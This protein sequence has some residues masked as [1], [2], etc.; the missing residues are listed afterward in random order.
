[1]TQRT[2]PATL[3]QYG[4]AFRATSLSATTDAKIRAAIDN[5]QRPR[6]HWFP[7]VWA[8]PFAAACAALTLWIYVSAD[9]HACEVTEQSDHTRYAGQCDVELRTMAV[10]LSPGAVVEEHDSRVRLSHGAAHFSVHK[11]EPGHPPVTVTL[12]DA[13]IEV[14]GTE[15]TVEISHNVSRVH[16]Q[17]GRVRFLRQGRGLDTGAVDMVPGQ[18]LTFESRTGK[19]EVVTLDANAASDPNRLHDALPAEPASAPVNATSSP[20]SAPSPEPETTS[21]SPNNSNDTKRTTQGAARSPAAPTAPTSTAATNTAT[22][23]TVQS[24]VLDEALRLRAAGRYDEALAALDDVNPQG[25][26]AREV[27]DYERAALTE[28]TSPARACVRY[29]RHLVEFPQSRYRAA[30][31]EKLAQCN[32]SVDSRAKSTS[33]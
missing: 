3:K 21:Q 9:S 29:R 6:R 24:S 12:P 10:Q 22:A 33:E 31:L 27:V 26:R 15:F 13:S 20:S 16:L 32:T 2:K 17:S 5:P 25:T 4:R 7:L 11:V 28:H 14:L 18:L 23:G 30:V 1:M 8:T 19:T